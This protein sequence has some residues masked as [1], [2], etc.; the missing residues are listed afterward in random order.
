M[1]PRDDFRKLNS[2]DLRPVFMSLG[3]A[4]EDFGGDSVPR[5]GQL[6]DAAL[7]GGDVKP[8]V[9]WLF[10]GDEYLTFDL[11]SNRFVDDAKRIA[12][13]WGGQSWPSMFS[14]G[15]DG[16]VWAGPA[17][18]NLWYMFKDDQFIRLNSDLGWLVDVG[19]Q[20][21]T[22]G[23]FSAQGTWFG[24]A[25]DVALHGIGARHHGRLHLFRGGEYMRH[26]LNDGHRDIGPVAIR[27]EWNL[28]EPFAAGVELAFY[29]VR[30]LSETIFFFA[31]GLCALYD[32]EAGVTTKVV[33]I[34]QQFPA[35]AEFMV[36]P[37]LF[38]VENYV[39][40]TY[41]G[42][43]Q[44]GALVETRTVP[45]GSETRT[46]MVTETTDSSTTTLRHSI[47]DSQDRSV[48]DN[49]NKQ[50]D[51][52]AEED[53]NSE[54]YRYHMNADFHGEA[55]ATSVWGGEVNASLNVQGGSDSL[56][57]RFAGSTFETIG[58]QITEA[59]QQVTQRTVDS[60]TQIQH[61]ERV[62]NQQEFVMK[63]TS[64]RLRVFEFY[65]QLQPYL[66]LLVLKD[67]RVA[68]ADG[69]PGGLRTVRL[70]N[71]PQFLQDAITNDD[72]RATLASFVAGELAS[73]QDHEGQ[74]KALLTADA[75]GLQL[76]SN[77]VATYPIQHANGDVQTISTRGLVIKAAKQW[78]APTLTM[79]GVEVN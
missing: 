36:R 18:S 43:P 75:G 39:L 44:L 56:R 52:R 42:P 38:L 20:T 6:F 37:Q 51:K 68:Y 59:T 40:E 60:S 2:M 54:K 25:V 57:E 34:E 66:T 41:V 30:D 4:A 45:P 3:M 62:L 55:E 9:V 28:P 78:L 76:L 72:R 12:G 16:A 22:S 23:W 32:T 10:K 1:A 49:F 35:F 33:P 15:I 69:T 31:E 70:P 26:N 48:V 63:N 14:S 24:D 21:R 58:S 65:Q 61:Q 71:L 46:L 74:P 7:N 13:N 77:P 67:V 29:G 5:R 53:S 27:E 73:V 17:F 19:P 8:D 79:I 47:L 11:R 64:D 50:Q